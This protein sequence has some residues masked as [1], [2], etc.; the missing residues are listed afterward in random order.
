MSTYFVFF[1]I[2]EQGIKA[3]QDSPARI[4]AA[5][6]MFEEQGVTVKDHYA[7]LGS[8][9]DTVFILEAPREE[10]VTKVALKVASLGNVRTSTHRAFTQEEWKDLVSL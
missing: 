4:E 1:N 8:F 5:R 2:T 6:G 9:Y 7:L 10:P 3:I